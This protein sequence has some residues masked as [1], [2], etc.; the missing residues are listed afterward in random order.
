MISSDGAAAEMAEHV[1]ERVERVVDTVVERVGGGSKH[2][3]ASDLIWKI[4]GCKVSSK[5]ILTSTHPRVL[6]LEDRPAADLGEVQSQQSGH[7]FGPRRALGEEEVWMAKERLGQRY[8]EPLDH[9][10]ERGEGM[11]DEWQAR[12]E[13]YRQAYPAE[14]SQQEEALR[15]DLSEGWDRSLDE[16]LRDGDTPSLPARLRAG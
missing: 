16:L 3:T 5:E 4:P 13:A 1:V 7:G 2:I 14:A 9:F 6:V 15:G 10:R 12:L 8:Q 11:K